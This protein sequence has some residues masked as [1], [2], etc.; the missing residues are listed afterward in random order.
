MFALAIVGVC[1]ILAATGQLYLKKGMNDVSSNNENL[2]SQQGL[3]NTLFNKY[4]FL[5]LAIYILGTI[6]WLFALA[7]LDLS[8]AYPLISIGYI[9]TAVFAFVFL[10]ENITLLRWGGIALV[11]LG[12]LLIIKSG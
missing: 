7:Q 10:K 5:G 8:L 11:V 1:I 9:I 3:L 6:L 12:S 4:V 2:F